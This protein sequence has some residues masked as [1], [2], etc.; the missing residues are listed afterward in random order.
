MQSW[1][2]KAGILIIYA[3]IL[4]GCGGGSSKPNTTVSQ[5][6]VS[7]TSFSLNSG[8]VGQL[9]IAALN[10]AGT[11]V[12][13]TF[14]FTSSNPSLVTVSTG[15]FVC[16]GVWDANFV[17]CNVAKDPLGNPLTGSANITATANGVNSTPVS[18]AVHQQLSSII[19]SPVAGC[20]SINKT[21]QF[22]ATAC[23]AVATPHDSSGPCAPNAKDI[24]SLVGPFAWTQTTTLVG[25]VD[26]NGLVTASAPGMMGVIAS[27][28][29]VRSSATPFR[30]C[31]PVA[32]RLHLSTDSGG[33]LTTSASMTT[34]Q[35]LTLEADMDDENGV[36]IPNAPVTIVSNSNTA[37]SVSATTLTANSP[38]GAGI[39]AACIPPGCGANL[40]LPIYSNLFST[41]VNGTSPATTVYVSTT[42]APPVG[43]FSTLVPLDTS[44]NT[45]GTAINLPGPPN[46]LVFTSNGA[47]AYM[48]TTAGLASIDTASSAATLVAANVTGKV[49]AV[50][51]DGNMV[52]LS[53]AASAPNP[54]TGVIG[55]IEPDPTKQ[56]LVIF[57]A[58]ASTVQ[59]FVVP[60]AVAAAFT[61]DSFKAF[62]V[63]NNGSGNVYVFSPFSALQTVNVAGNSSDIT[64]LASG[65][66][67]F[68]ANAAGLEVMSTCNS[69]Q[70]PTANNPPT[71][72]SSIQLV[73]PF[74]NSNIFVAVDSP[75]IDVETATVTPLTA[76]LVISPA[77]CPPGVTY[78]NQFIDFGVGAFTARQLL[79]AGNAVG[80]NGDPT[81]GTHI[82]VLPVG[83]NQLLTAVAGAAPS[84]K[85]IPLG[86]AGATEALSGGLTLDGNTAWVGVAGSNT[87]DKID[88]VGGSDTNQIVTSFKKGDSTAAPPNLVAVKPK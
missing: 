35:T 19:V 86:A 9:G 21:Q 70:Q 45:L 16:A 68:L 64:T 33:S 60:G 61:G 63:T 10:S 36:T 59:S 47:K 67:A 11:P 6:T 38:G 50:S 54:L 13:A 41:T 72:S 30:T 46:S 56:R 4:A 5:V 79:V 48:G 8:E 74:A 12:A 53:N 18:V 85:A 52:I 55:P 29:N 28:G 27:I 81:N 65:P 83:S 80:N 23:S 62:V 71:H 31:M 42:F 32:I 22:Q 66:F 43:S 1:V 2:G 84:V 77:S 26:T 88:L 58:N 82:V 14:T 44:T 24:T 51:P 49:L 40:N 75:G 7:P 39:L 57:T 87:V 37:A 73:Q 69:V 17:V 78:S 3:A 20:T 25:T 34:T 15:G 76:P